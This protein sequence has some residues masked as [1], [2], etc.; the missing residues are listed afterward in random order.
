MGFQN[1][2]RPLLTSNFLVFH[3]LDE[4]T[5]PISHEYSA[6]VKKVSV[7]IDYAAVHLAD[8]RL[9][10]HIIE[11]SDIQPERESRLFPAA[12]AKDQ[13]AIIS[14]HIKGEMLIYSTQNGKIHYFLLDEWNEVNCYE[15]KTNLKSIYPDQVATRLLLIDENSHGAI[16]SPVDDSLLPIDQVSVKLRVESLA[17]RIL[18]T[19]ILFC[20]YENNSINI[21]LVFCHHSRLSLGR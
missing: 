4:D 20:S 18:E 11:Q 14:S 1:V 8:G 19:I 7:G 5:E 6:T 10:L 21:F 17:R 2:F 3:T 15:H 12:N 13:S 16:Y 9:H